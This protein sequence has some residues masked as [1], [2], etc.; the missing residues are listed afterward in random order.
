MHFAFRSK[1]SAGHA[2]DASRPGQAQD[3]DLEPAHRSGHLPVHARVKALRIYLKSYLVEPGDHQCQFHL[4]G[5][6]NSK[7]AYLKL[8]AGPEDKVQ[9]CEE[10]EVF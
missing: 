7:S 10:K 5:G 3:Q 6:P 8:A 1:T 2:L 9:V 4:A